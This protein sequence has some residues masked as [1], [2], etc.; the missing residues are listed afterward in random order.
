MGCE[1]LQILQFAYWVFINS[2]TWP[3][4]PL[5]YFFS[6]LSE[7]FPMLYSILCL[8]LSLCRVIFYLV[9]PSTSVFFV[10]VDVVS[11]S[12]S[13]DFICVWVC[14]LSWCAQHM[15]CKT[16]IVWAHDRKR[17]L[18]NTVTIKRSY[19]GQTIMDWQ[20]QVLIGKLTKLAF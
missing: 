9:G 6:Y 3:P 13:L 14:E 10:S 17:R 11:I 5:R 18:Y 20:V 19:L 2:F 15:R 4:F 7:W 12:A 16:Q 8:S 1:G